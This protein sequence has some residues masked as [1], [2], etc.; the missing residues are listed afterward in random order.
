MLPRAMLTRIER[1]PAYTLGVFAYSGGTMPVLEPPWKGNRRRESCIPPGE[2]RC[3]IRR[4]PRFG[5]RYW[6]PGAAPREWIL[7]HPG[8]LVRNTLGCLLP[9]KRA[10]WLNGKRAVFNS[11]AALR[12]LERAFDCRPFILEIRD[13]PQEV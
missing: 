1:G 3:E 12:L 13:A 5:R 10:G 8:N 2:Y 9:G 11:R 6:L 4:S 7:I